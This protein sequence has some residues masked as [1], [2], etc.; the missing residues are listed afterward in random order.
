MVGAA[1]GKVILYGDHAVA[2]GRPALVAALDRGVRAEVRPGEPAIV[3]GE[4]D[5][6][7]KDTSPARAFE[8][9]CAA[10]GRTARVH[11]FFDVPVRA[12]LGS[13]APCAVAVARALGVAEERVFEVAQASEQV[14]HGAP[15]GVDV[16]AARRGGVGW[17]TRKDGWRDVACAP[18][19]LCVGLSGRE[20]STAAL[21]GRV[22]RLCADQPRRARELLDGIAAIVEQAEA[23]LANG[24]A[25]TLGRLFDA[26]HRS[27]CELGVGSPELDELCQAARKAGALGAKLTGAGGG[28]AVIA[29]APGCEADILSAWRGAGYAGF[30]TRI[31]CT[32]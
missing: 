20:R 21:V 19:T 16:E 28:G 25:A 2:Q 26:N 30:V 10:A 18:M 27:L 17:F 9:L 4:S 31:P 8:A 29:L 7:P 1:R 13:S 15:S 3:L 14:F 11:V 23:A 32:R 12:G 24:D 5:V 22:T 6:V